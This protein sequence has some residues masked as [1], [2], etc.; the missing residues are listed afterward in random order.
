[1]QLI[2]GRHQ[3]GNHALC[4]ITKGWVPQMYAFYTRSENAVKR[5]QVHTKARDGDKTSK[6]WEWPVRGLTKRRKASPGYFEHYT[7]ALRHAK[8]VVNATIARAHTRDESTHLGLGGTAPIFIRTP[9]GWPRDK[10]ACTERGIY[11]SQRRERGPG[12]AGGGGTVGLQE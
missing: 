11:Q 7:G 10:A 4:D 12:P 8:K 3:K 5:R 9:R 1:M 6:G 2:Q